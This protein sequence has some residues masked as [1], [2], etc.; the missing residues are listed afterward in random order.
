MFGVSDFFLSGLA[1]VKKMKGH[2]NVFC[3]EIIFILFFHLEEEIYHFTKQ[4][5]YEKYS[6]D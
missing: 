2:I 4:N 5:F 3:K 6:C 1:I